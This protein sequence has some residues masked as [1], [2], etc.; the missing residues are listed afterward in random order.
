M[1]RAVGALRI[2]GSSSGN[3][4]VGGSRGDVPGWSRG[5]GGLRDVSGL[6]PSAL[7]IC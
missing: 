2:W 7:G 6:W 1:C 4:L 5:G 3:G